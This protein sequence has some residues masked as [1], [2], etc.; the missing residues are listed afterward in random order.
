MTSLSFFLAAYALLAIPGP[1]NTLLATAGAGAGISRSL[2]LLAAELCG[3]CLAIGLLRLVLG[4]IVMEIPVAGVV[5]RL[6]ITLYVLHLASMLWRA[7]PHELRDAAPVRF[8]HVLLAT[9]LNP[10]ALIFAFALLPLQATLLTLMP[11]LALLALQIVTAGAA[12]IAFGATLGLGL[13]GLGRPDLVNRLGATA[14]V[15]VAGV[16]WLPSLAIT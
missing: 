14:L 7:R 8:G 16:I 1:T 9:L 11:W 10:K 5:L 2:H 4:P 3:Y 12:W 6:A 15:A 13:R